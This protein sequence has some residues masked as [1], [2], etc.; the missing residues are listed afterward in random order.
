MVMPL[1]DLNPART[2]PLVNVSLIAL[3]VLGF[4]YELGLGV[5]LEGFLMSAAFVPERYF[6]PGNLGADLQ[7]IVVSMFLHGGWMH[8]LGNMLYL[9]I[10]G[11]NVEDRL[12]HARYLVFYL[13]AGWAATLAHAVFNPNSSIPSIGAS[14]AIAGVLGAYAYLFPHARVLTLIPLGF[15]SQLQE[16]P[17]L[18]VLGLWFVLQLFSGVGELAVRTAQSGGVAWWA[19]IGGFVAGLVLIVVLGGKRRAQRPT[20]RW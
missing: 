10:F 18:L 20:P 14:G 19:H 16:L 9:W 17:A 5:R 3:N 12:G 2:F 1:K 15:Y 8:L 11:D 6:V 4:F 13:L 7:S